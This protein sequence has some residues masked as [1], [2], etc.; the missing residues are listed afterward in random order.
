M[1]VRR[2]RNELTESAPLILCSLA[3]ETTPSVKS[4]IT[5]HGPPS[6]PTST[7]PSLIFV[8]HILGGELTEKTHSEV[9]ELPAGAI[10]KPVMVEKGRCIL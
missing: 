8:H 10:W 3:C 4:P 1:V 6:A 7:R 5:S 2:E 9:E